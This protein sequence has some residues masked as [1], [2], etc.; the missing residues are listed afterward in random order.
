[1][2]CWKI[3]WRL[4]VGRPKLKILSASSAFVQLWCRKRIYAILSVFRTKIF[5]KRFLRWCLEWLCVLHHPAQ[6]FAQIEDVQISPH[7]LTSIAHPSRR[8]TGHRMVHTLSWDNQLRQ[9][10]KACNPLFM[11]T[12]KLCGQAELNTQEMTTLGTANW[13]D[14]P[15]P[16]FSKPKPR[17]SRADVSDP[18]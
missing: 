1:M 4:I 12:K 5:A 8:G 14:S 6:S 18:A 10:H 17:A 13:L 9:V 11:T 7:L 3:F 15:S 2:N 16:R